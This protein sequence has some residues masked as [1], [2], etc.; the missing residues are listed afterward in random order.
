MPYLSVA[1][2]TYNRQKF[3]GACLECLA[4][5]TLEKAKWEAIVIDNNST[6]RS[7]EIVNHFITNHPH[8][9]FR[10]VFE[11]RQGLSFAR[12]RGI[13]ES[14]GEVIVYID[15]DVEVVPEYLQTI[16]DFFTNHPDAVGMG[17]RTFPKFSEGPPPQ[18]LSPYVSGITG[19]TDRGEVMRKYTKRMKYPVGCNMAYRKT[20]LDAV[21]R[22][23]EALKARADDKYIYEKVSRLNDDV[24]YVPKAFSLHNIDAGRLT[25]ASFKK[26][27]TKGGSEEKIKTSAEGKWSYFKKA[28]DLTAKL[29]ISA[30]LWILYAL[31]GKAVQGRYIFLSQ[32]YTFKGF[33]S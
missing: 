1:I 8:L 13:D 17:G 20:I 24:W 27:Y 12:N 31:K 3:I 29:G 2:C 7:A 16:Y 11:E 9:P 10:Y 28:V 23:N 5:Q 22:F 30:G 14:K 15:D 21:G 32:W 6:D 19:T 4:K 33:F 25:D 18:W 26:L